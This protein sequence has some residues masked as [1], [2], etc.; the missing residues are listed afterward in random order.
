[1][2]GERLI[3]AD[4]TIIENGRAGSA[5]GVL[6]LY[7]PGWTMANAAQIFMNSVM[8]HRIRYEYGEMADTY[9]GFTVCKV[10]MDDGEGMISVCL[11]KG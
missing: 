3:L 7:V 2:E 4:G 1:M 6:W 10:L 9:E 8:T 11:A 5:G